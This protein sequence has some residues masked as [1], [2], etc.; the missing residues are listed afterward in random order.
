MKMNKVQL[1]Q[2]I[3]EYRQLVVENMGL[4]AVKASLK[5]EI[6]GEP[7]NVDV[8]NLSENVMH[9]AKAVVMCDILQTM[10]VDF[11]VEREEIEWVKL[12]EDEYV[13]PEVQTRIIEEG[14]KVVEDALTFAKKE[15]TK[16]SGVIK[17]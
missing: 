10:P 11:D 16:I 5:H 4:R 7:A 13:K 17:P 3:S 14:R 15:I 2:Q 6:T 1:I 9:A 12:V 8:G